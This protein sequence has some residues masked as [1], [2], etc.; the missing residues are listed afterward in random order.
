MV[1]KMPP[2]RSVTRRNAGLAIKLMFE[3]EL[4]DSLD[5]PIRG[6]VAGQAGFK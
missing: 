6:L 5:V 2:D 4:L 3:D 1:S